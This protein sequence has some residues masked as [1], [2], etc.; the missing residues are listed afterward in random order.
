MENTTD[1]E[2]VCI[3]HGLSLYI[4]A[5]GYRLLFDT[6][7]SDAFAKNAKV[8]GVDLSKVDFAVL[9]HGHY[10]H[11]GGLKRF[12]EIND[13]AP[14][15]VNQHAFGY[16]YSGDNYIGLSRE[17]E[18]NERLIVVEE[19]YRINEHM[20]LFSCNMRPRP[21][22]SYADG[23]K[24]RGRE[25]LMPDMFRHEQYLLITEGDRRIL[26]SGCSH[27]GVLNILYW[28]KPDILVGGFHFMKVN[29][30]VN[31]HRLEEALRVFTASDTKYFTCHCTGRE[32]YAYLKEKMGEQLQYLSA[33]CQIEL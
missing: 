17:L 21:Y 13:H 29:P 5:A 19:E 4:E 9:S 24:V 26:I 27:K 7:Q 22:D 18:G 20:T 8:L 14:V 6:G 10:D 28:F 11:G 1:R 33:G 32:Q 12:L 2:D 25:T 15:Y 16:Y 31:P 30:A 3:E 23:L